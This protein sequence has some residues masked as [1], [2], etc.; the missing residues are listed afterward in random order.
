MF[1]YLFGG[2]I[3]DYFAKLAVWLACYH[4]GVA[5]EFAQD[6]LDFLDLDFDTT[7]ADNI[8]DAAFDYKTAF[9]IE[10]NHIICVQDVGIKVRGIDNQTSSFV[11]CQADTGQG[12]VVFFLSCRRCRGDS[13]HCH[14]AE[15]LGHSVCAPDIVWKSTEFVFQLQVNCTAADYQMPDAAKALAFLGNLQRFVYLQWNHGG[16]INGFIDIFQWMCGGLTA[17][18]I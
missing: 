16:K 15:R 6:G 5:E 2:Q 1:V 14:V 17:D 12:F 3:Y 9:V 4:D 7:A 18:K 11:L 8:V 10:F 13:S